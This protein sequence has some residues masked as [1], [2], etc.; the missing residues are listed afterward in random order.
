[1]GRCQGAQCIPDMGLYTTSLT[2]TTDAAPAIPGP[3]TDSRIPERLHPFTASLPSPRITPLLNSLSFNYSLPVP[4]QAGSAPPTAL[5]K[6][7]SCPS[8]L[9]L[10]LHPQFQARHP[11]PHLDTR[12]PHGDAGAGSTRRAEGS[13]CWQVVSS[14]WRGGVE[15]RQ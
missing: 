12:N 2:H 10:V 8:S 5:F 13:C 6:F 7:H 11:N 14:P 3:C 1:M 15:A 9:T 4:E